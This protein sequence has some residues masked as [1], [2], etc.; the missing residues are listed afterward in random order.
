MGGEIEKPRVSREYSPLRS[1]LTRGERN[2]IDPVFPL[3]FRKTV[4]R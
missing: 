4:E 2:G 3:L 1:G